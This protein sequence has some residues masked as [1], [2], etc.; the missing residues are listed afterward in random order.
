MTYHEFKECICRTIQ[1]ELEPDVKVTVQ[2]IIKNNGTH[3]DGLTILSP[4][5]NISPT[6]Y[7]NYYYQ[8]YEKGKSLQKICSEILKIY[9]QSH[10]NENIDVSFFTD[11]DKVKSTIVFKLINYE[12]NKELLGQIP[13]YRYLDLAIVF[14]CLVESGYTGYATIL[15]YHHHLKLWNITKDDLYALAV[16][17]TPRLLQ[18]DLRDMTEMLNEL[19][20]SE[21]SNEPVFDRSTANACPL[22]ILTNQNKLNGS[23]CILYHNLLKD[24]SKRI[25]SDLYILPSSIHEVLILPAYANSCNDLSEIVKEVNTTQ[26]SPEEILSDHVYYFSKDTGKLTM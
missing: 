21:D 17:N 22:Y 7:L 8:Q 15:I 25:D 6:I 11:Y 18:Y 3:L 1:A 13:H 23:V 2:D 4:L 19:F 16:F 24:F 14:C 20:L 26:L 5:S 12:R 10:L 9:R